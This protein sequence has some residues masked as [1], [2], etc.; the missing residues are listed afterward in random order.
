MGIINFV[1][2]FVPD[3]VFMV[4]PIHN[5]L[6]KY[7]SFSWIDEVEN[8]F[9]RI[10]KAISSALVLVKPNF[11]KYFIIYT[12]ATEETIFSILLQCDD[13]NNENS[14]AYM[15]QG[16]SDDEIKYY[17]I[18]KRVFS[19]VKAIQKFHH[20][21][22][23]KHTQVKFPFPDVKFLL[24]Q[25]YLSGKLAHWL[26]KIQDHN[27]RIMTS[28]KIKGRDLALHLVQ[29]PKP[30]EGL[31][32]QDNP[33]S[34]LFYFE[35]QNLS[36]S[37]HPW[38]INLVYY[39]QYQRCPDGLDPHQ[40]R[41]LLLEASKYTILGDLLF[42]RSAHGLL[43]QCVNDVEAQ[44]ILREIHG[45]S[46]SVIHIGGHF[47]AKA[48]AFKII[49]NGYHWPMIFHDSY[50]FARSCDKCQIF[51]GKERLHAMPLQPILSNFPFS[52]WGLD[53]I[54][55]INPPSSAGHIFILTTTDYFTKWNEVGPLR[56][57]QD[58]QVVSFLESNI[59][60]IFGIP[61]EI[62]T[63]NDPTFIS[64][65]LTQFLA[66]LGVKHFTSSAYYP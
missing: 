9:L 5:L 63:N 48:I 24:S 20:F 47:F 25:T 61:L 59:F 15:S 40:R 44:K 19:L 58:E 1:H 64:A 29:H 34:M 33:L 21:I 66:T 41:R 37:E 11:D 28:K 16:I 54:V 26:A 62:I 50:K 39:L 65:K 3:F 32:D 38:Y 49:R 45:S 31:D 12:N 23:G 10:K 46:T 35:N 55:S 43:L 22:L 56:H 36:L 53:L 57:A 52:K 8:A 2:R 51:A 42:R 7:H 4:K 17:Y 18:E 6:K 30:S 60:S 27:L 13:Q 14:I